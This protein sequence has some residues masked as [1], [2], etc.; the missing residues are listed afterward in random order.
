ME[1]EVNRVSTLV[2]NR[3]CGWNDFSWPLVVL[4]RV[5]SFTVTLGLS[6]MHGNYISE[7]GNMAMSLISILPML[8]IFVLFQ[9]YLVAGIA[10]TGAR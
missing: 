4:Q 7:S 6:S 8:L 1:F 5:E 2:I 10:T 3:P 9:R